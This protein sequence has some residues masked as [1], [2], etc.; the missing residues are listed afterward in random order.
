MDVL[1]EGRRTLSLGDPDVVGDAAADA[2]EQLAPPPPP[3]TITAALLAIKS[4]ILSLSLMTEGCFE[5]LILNVDFSDM[6]CMKSTLSKCVGTAIVGGSCL[7]KLPQVVNLWRAASAAGLS[8]VGTMLELVAVTASGAYSFAN[9]FP[10]GAYGEAIFLSLQ[11]CVVALLILWYSGRRAASA[12]LAAAYAVV[13]AAVLTPGVIPDKVLWW[14]QA[15]NI[16]MVVVGKLIQVVMNFR[17]GHT[18][19]MSAVTVFMLAAGSIARIFTSIQETGDEI[20]ILT[21]ICASTVNI[22][23]ALQVV[24]Y[25]N[26]TKECMSA[27]KTKLQ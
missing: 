16:P 4:V 9:G 15:A 1:G 3:T 12:A 14:G 17:N 20:L 24:F 11:T 18:G 8:F 6:E 27:K 2:A 10:F 25:W 23:L 26:V 19:V 13:V 7:V 21:Y 5:T 22:M